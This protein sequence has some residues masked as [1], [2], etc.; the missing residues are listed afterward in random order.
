[1]TS[2]SVVLR[3]QDRRPAFWVFGDVLPDVVIVASVCGFNLECV[4]MRS[5]QG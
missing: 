2:G 3:E 1:M 5:L 4:M